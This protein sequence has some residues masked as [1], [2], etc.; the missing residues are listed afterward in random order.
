MSSSV[1]RPD[2]PTW[3]GGWPWKLSPWEGEGRFPLV[4]WSDTQ[5]R[6]PAL[7]PPGPPQLRPTLAPPACAG[8]PPA[9]GSLWVCR[10]PG[11]EPAAAVAA[12]PGPAAARPAAASPAAAAPRPAAGFLGGERKGRGVG[13]VCREPGASWRARGR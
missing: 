10:L 4:L 8:R 6:L 1:K 3:W 9:P 11:T 5:H 12:A 7:S 13:E 2:L